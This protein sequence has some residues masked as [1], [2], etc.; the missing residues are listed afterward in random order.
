MMTSGYIKFRLYLFQIVAILAFSLVAAKLWQLQ[1][2][3]SQD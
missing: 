2:V 1:I 3:S